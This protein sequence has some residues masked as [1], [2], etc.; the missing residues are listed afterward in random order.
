MYNAQTHTA[1]ITGDQSAGMRRKPC[2]ASNCVP[3]RYG[4]T[5][6]VPGS[7]PRSCIRSA[8]INAPTTAAALFRATVER[9]TAK[10]AIPAS[11]RT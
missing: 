11:G 3:R 1:R 4:R 7:T 6:S 10:A 2:H 8:H 5:A 9:S